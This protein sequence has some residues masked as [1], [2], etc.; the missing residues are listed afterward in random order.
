[1]DRDMLYIVENS[2]LNIKSYINIIF[3]KEKSIN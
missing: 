3:L 1:M 2:K